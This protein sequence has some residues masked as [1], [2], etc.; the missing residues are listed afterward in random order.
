MPEG[1]IP[2]R[3]LVDIQGRL[4]IVNGTSPFDALR[5]ACWHW[6]RLDFDGREAMV[7]ELGEPVKMN[8]N[9]VRREPG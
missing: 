9:E 8:V 4:Y 7:Y 1:K 5:D 3:Y 6:T 2:R